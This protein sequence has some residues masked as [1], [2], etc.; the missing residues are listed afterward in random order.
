MAFELDTVLAAV[1]TSLKTATSVPV[2]LR[3][4]LPLDADGNLEFPEGG[5]FVILDVIPGAP[6]NSFDGTLY[7][8]LILQ[9][10]AWSATSL[11]DAISL[12]ELARAD[13]ATQGFM[14]TA[15]VALQRDGRFRGVIFTVTERGAFQS[16]T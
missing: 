13:L 4:A 5:R 10:S 3:D 6:S 15:G 11:T 12:A 8:D 14:R 7:E 16:L 1:R 2:E 9:V